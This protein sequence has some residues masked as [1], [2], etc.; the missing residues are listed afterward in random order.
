[1]KVLAIMGSP[2]KADSYGIT[3]LIEEGLGKRAAVEFKYFFLKD[4]HLEFCRG[5]CVCFARGEDS[6][7]V[8]DDARAIR[9]EMLASDGV[10]LASP[11]YAHQVTARM[12][13]FIDRF[14][15]LFHRPCF[16]DKAAV[17]LATT[18]GTGLSEVLRYLDMTAR[19][20]GFQVVHKVGVMAPA[21]EH[22]PRYK[23]KVTADIDACARKLCEA[24]KTKA[25]SAPG[26]FD[27]TF[28]R[29]MRAK[30]L[31]VKDY[32]P[33]DYNYW[34]QRGWLEKDY[35]L[36]LPINPFKD[37]FARL[38]ELLVMKAAKRKTH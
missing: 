24:M 27:L 15:Y 23:A 14:S 34:Q 35:Y 7:P 33:C 38:M 19:G 36:D 32:F 22:S 11:V 5:C 26:V 16:F 37:L 30:M 10:V 2:R 3:R 8:K 31:A 28:F 21:F 12:K 20:W 9:E 18:G 13:N 4:A 29:L 17:V 6:C 25:R 1:M